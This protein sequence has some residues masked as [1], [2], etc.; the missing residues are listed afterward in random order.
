MKQFTKV[1]NK[2]GEGFKYQHQ[3]FLALSEAIRKEVMFVV[4]DTRKL[5]K[6]T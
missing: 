5:M 4:P 6:E 2:A 3:F 1:L